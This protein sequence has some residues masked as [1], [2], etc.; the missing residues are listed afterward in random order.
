MALFQG[1]KKQFGPPLDDLDC[2]NA[3]KRPWSCRYRPACDGAA[4][5]DQEAIQ[6]SARWRGLRQCR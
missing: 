2:V 1:T 4:S 5:R 6:P 3:V